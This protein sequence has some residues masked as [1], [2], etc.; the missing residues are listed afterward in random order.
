M[1]NIIVREEQN[2]YFIK[3]RDYYINVENVKKRDV[4]T[5]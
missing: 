2:T 5:H 1:K 4:Y 3:E